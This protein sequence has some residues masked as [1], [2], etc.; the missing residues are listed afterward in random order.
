[1]ARPADVGLEQ[2]HAGVGGVPGFDDDVVELV[3]EELV[4]DALVLAI[5]FEEVGERADGGHAV[6]VLLVGVGLEDIA[7]GLGGVAVLADEG[8]ERAAAAVEGGDFAAQLV[9]AALGLRLFVAAGFDLE[10]KF[11]DLGFEALEA[12]GDGLEGERDLAALQAEGVEL[13]SGDLGLGDEAF[14]FALKTGESGGGLGL[15]VAGLA[16]ALDRAAWRRGGSARPAARLRR[17]RGRPPAPEP[18]GSGR[19]RGSLSD[20]AVAFSRKLRCCSSSPARLASCAWACA[21][22]SA[23]VA[24]RLVSSAMRSALAAVRAVMRSSS[25]ADWLACAP[26]SRICWSRA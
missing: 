12:L 22:S 14:G 26:A 6:G 13:L 9:A 16:D 17:R 19:P 11:G 3:A 7:D 24:R 2:V 23:P 20:S 4:D 5:D 18:A 10:A 8:F 21:S 15:L 25:T 1:M